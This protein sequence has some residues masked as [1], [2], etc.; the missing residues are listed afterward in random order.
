MFAAA[1]AACEVRGVT[2][3]RACEPAGEPGAAPAT[4]LCTAVFLAL[5]TSQ[6]TV[7]YECQLAQGLELR[8]DGMAQ[9]AQRRSS[10][11]N[12]CLRAACN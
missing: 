2:C 7:D 3:M 4:P 10:I 8:P 9:Q 6:Q 1:A 5:L 12:T 11:D